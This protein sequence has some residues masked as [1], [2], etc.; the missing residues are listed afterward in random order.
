MDDDGDTSEQGITEQGSSSG[1]GGG[2]SGS[3]SISQQLS[4]LPTLQT[5]QAVPT[6]DAAYGSVNFWDE[7]YM[8]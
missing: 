4:Q 8:T 3:D 6:D 1:G 2:E 7:R 5:Y